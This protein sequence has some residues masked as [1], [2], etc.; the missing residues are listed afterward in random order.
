MSWF[1]LKDQPIRKKRKGIWLRVRNNDDVVQ[2]IK[3]SKLMRVT[4]EIECIEIKELRPNNQVLLEVWCSSFSIW[5]RKGRERF[6]VF[7]LLVNENEEWICEGDLGRG[8]K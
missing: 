2:A 1:I 4:E 5:N 3:K 8:L 7:Y 6:N